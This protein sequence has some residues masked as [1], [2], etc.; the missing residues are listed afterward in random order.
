[1]TEPSGESGIEFVVE[2]AGRRGFIHHRPVVG[3]APCELN[4]VEFFVGVGKLAGVVGDE[5][6]PQ[7]FKIRVILG[8]VVTERNTDRGCG[9]HLL[10][11]GALVGGQRSAFDFIFL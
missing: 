6:W 5:D 8:A 3:K 9:E 10:N 1:M 4:L 2:N 7:R 11:L